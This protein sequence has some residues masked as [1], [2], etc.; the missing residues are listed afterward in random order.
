MAEPHGAWLARPA[1]PFG[2][3]GAV[4]AAASSRHQRKADAA[5]MSN[6]MLTVLLASAP[7]CAAPSHDR[8]VVQPGRDVC[9]ASLNAKG[10]PR[11]AGFLPTGC[12]LPRQ[13]YRVDARGEADLC[14]DPKPGAPQ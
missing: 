10:E 2:P 12:P 8:L 4:R 1:S 11:A 6:L 13:T 7:V 5:M 9:A 14:T 3:S